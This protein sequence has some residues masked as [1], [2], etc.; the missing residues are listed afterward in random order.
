MSKNANL[1]LRRINPYIKQFDV[2]M[3][4]GLQSIPK[5]YTLSEKKTILHNIINTYKPNSL[6]IGSIISPK[7]VPQMKHSFEL[8]NYANSIYNKDIKDIKDNVVINN[9][10]K[11]KF[12]LSV[13][14]TK[15]Y[16]N[17]AKALNIK[18]ISLLTSISD[19]YQQKY[20]KQSIQKTKEIF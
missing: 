18:N 17:T 4:D 12:Y 6:E 15:Q 3:S 1:L 8:Y 14:P 9:N 2:S 20:I 10:N 19:E 13:P 11:C 7:V 16:L 5:K